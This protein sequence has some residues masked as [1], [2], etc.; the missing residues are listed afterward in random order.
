MV[1]HFHATLRHAAS[2]DAKADIGLV[3][4]VL[5]PASTEKYVA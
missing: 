3:V 4:K 1:L 5:M 2:I